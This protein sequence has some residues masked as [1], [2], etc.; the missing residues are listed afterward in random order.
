MLIL[1]DVHIETDTE[2]RRA[3]LIGDL[4]HLII[5][6]ISPSYTQLY[7][8]EIL[9]VEVQTKCPLILSVVAQLH[10]RQSHEVGRN[11]KASEEGYRVAL[12][13]QETLSGRSDE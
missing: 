4:R 2:I 12:Q 1:H 8:G 10:L 9:V 5:L 11:G 7:N 13:L 3:G 6:V